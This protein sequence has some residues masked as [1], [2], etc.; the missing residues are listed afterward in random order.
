MSCNLRRL[1]KLYT[2]YKSVDSQDSY[3]PP[4]K[5]MYY[6]VHSDSLELAGRKDAK[7]LLQNAPSH[8]TKTGGRSL[9][10]MIS[11]FVRPPSLL[12]IQT[13]PGAFSRGGSGNRGGPCDSCKVRGKA[14]ETSC[15]LVV[16]FCY[17]AP[18]SPE[19]KMRHFC[20]SFS[21]KTRAAHCNAPNTAVEVFEKFPQGMA[22]APRSS[23][24]ISRH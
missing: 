18:L 10:D 20:S 19:G 24:G 21:H 13:T 14:F 6:L 17:D 9:K 4:K 12:Y 22:G 3:L 23:R 16:D 7:E 5:E 1:N 2:F 11:L 15:S 8:T